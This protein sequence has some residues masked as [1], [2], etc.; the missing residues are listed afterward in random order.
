MPKSPKGALL[1][2]LS[3]KRNTSVPIYRQIDAFLRRLILEGN[4]QPGQKLPSTR[5]LAAELNVSRITVKTVYEQLLTEGFVQSK[6]GA[7][8]FVA[9]G[10]ELKILPNFQ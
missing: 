7:G 1:H 6:T 9:D 10:L 5:E 3:I 2:D 8:T 4:L